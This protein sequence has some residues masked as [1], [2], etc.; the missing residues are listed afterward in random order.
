[1][2]VVLA[3][4]HLLFR[5]GLARMLADEQVEVVG[6]AAD[7]EQ[8]MRLMTS[9]SVDVAIVDIRMP[10]SYTTEGLVA[11]RRLADDHPSVGVLILSEYLESHYA[12]RLVTQ[13]GQVVDALHR[14]AR[15]EFV[16]DPGVVSEL[17]RRPTTPER[18][19]DLLTDREREVL[20]LMAEGRSNQGICDRLYLTR[21]TVETHVR[22]IFSKLGLPPVGDDH[23]RVL[24]V[25]A[26]L[27]A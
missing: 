25:L 26:Y 3:D 22:S 1:V 12:M 17:V 23:R 6:Q 5:E 20:A 21:K 14:V 24:A 10:P 18:P 16:I 2:R 13:V 7:A 15:G 11:A 4:D 19:V 27:S 9:V 8:L